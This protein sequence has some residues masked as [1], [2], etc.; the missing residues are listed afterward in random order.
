[1]TRYMLDTNTVSDVMKENEAVSART[2]ATPMESLCI[3]AITL[4]ELR[5]GIAK[6][7]A[8]KLE[9]ALEEFLKRV[10][11][12]PWDERVAEKYGVL[13]A[14]LESGGCKMG[15][16]D[17]LIAG[18]ALGVGAVLVTSDGAFS[19]VSGLKVENWRD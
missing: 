11:V 5:F 7:K 19:Q 3:S 17:M 18:H 6:R 2:E 9:R 12:L 1:M 4:G 16:L 15:N 8:P 10:D 13:R 14:L